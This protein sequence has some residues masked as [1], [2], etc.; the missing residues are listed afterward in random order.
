MKNTKGVTTKAIE[1]KFGLYCSPTGEIFFEDAFI[2][3][4]AVLGEVNQG[5]K[6]CMSMLDGTRLSCAARAVAVGQAAMDASVAYT[7]ER[8]QFGKPISSFQMVQADLVQMYVE[9]EAARLLVLKAAA[10]RDEG[11][12]RNTAEISTAKYFAAEAAVHAAN[13]AMKL[14]GSYGFSLEYP[15]A[16]LLRDSKSFQ[17]VE[18]TS[19]VQKIVI[20]RHMLSD[21]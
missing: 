21:A 12:L 19:N 6:I 17:I 8:T 11:N 14:F 4:D 16:R 18:G 3:D 10:T 13:S 9:H 7:K 2:P 1:E 20:A 15:A 5:F